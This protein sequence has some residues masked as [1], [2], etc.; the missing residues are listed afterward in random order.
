MGTGLSALAQT[1]AAR[2]D[3]A[4][5]PFADRAEA[6]KPGCNFLYEAPP[7]R[8]WSVTIGNLN[9][10]HPSRYSTKDELRRA[11]KDEME[12]VECALSLGRASAAIHNRLDKRYSQLLAGVEEISQN[13]RS[14]DYALEHCGDFLRIAGQDA[15]GI[16]NSSLAEAQQGMY[17]AREWLG[18]GKK[19]LGI[20]PEDDAV[21]LDPSRKPN[22]AR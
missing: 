21:P 20:A 18:K 4:A 16:S 14:R 3:P 12:F 6:S 8:H 1:D 13:L 17:Y 22:V 11:L 19:C 5:P 10:S 9:L 15:V 7:K 2:A